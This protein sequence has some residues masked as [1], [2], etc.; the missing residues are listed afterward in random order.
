MPAHEGHRLCRRV[1]IRPFFAAAR[2]VPPALLFE[3]PV[4]EVQAVAPI[5]ARDEEKATL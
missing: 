1:Y 3:D 4:T 5:G 2:K